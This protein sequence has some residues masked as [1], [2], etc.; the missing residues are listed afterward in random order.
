MYVPKY[1]LLRPYNATCIYILRTDIL[2]MDKELD[3]KHTQKHQQQQQNLKKHKWL[4][5]TVK[6]FNTLNLRGN[7]KLL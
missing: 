3:K 1:N 4:R 7:E 5:S 2:K 6:T